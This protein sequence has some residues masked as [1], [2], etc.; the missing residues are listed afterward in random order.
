[1]SSAHTKEVAEQQE[2]S[3]ETPRG[4][5]EPKKSQDVADLNNLYTEPRIAKKVAYTK[6]QHTEPQR[7][8]GTPSVQA[9]NL[10]HKPQRKI[11]ETL[12]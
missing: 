4:V 12:D 10:R 8:L 6:Q 9:K 5:A 11:L 7:K 1:M 2:A 3:E